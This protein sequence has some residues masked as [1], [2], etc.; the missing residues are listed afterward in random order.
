MILLVVVIQFALINAR[1]HDI[2]SVETTIEEK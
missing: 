2:Q 1:P